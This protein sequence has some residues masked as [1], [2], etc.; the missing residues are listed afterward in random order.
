MVANG[1]YCIDVIK[2][3]FA[4]QRA[5]EKVNALLMEDHLQTCASTAIRSTDRAERERTI[6][7]LLDVFETSG[8]L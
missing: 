5:L 1:A 7:E 4:I 8:R 6:R 3:T 2:Q